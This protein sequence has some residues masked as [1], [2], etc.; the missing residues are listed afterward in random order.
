MGCQTLGT[1][2]ANQVF[3]PT[4][5]KLAPLILVLEDSDGVVVTTTDDPFSRTIKGNASHRRRMSVQRQE[6][7]WLSGDIVRYSLSAGEIVARANI[8]QKNSLSGV[9]QFPGVGD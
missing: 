7:N 9:V 8:G 6:L 5:K 4:P 2:K 3:T 1:A